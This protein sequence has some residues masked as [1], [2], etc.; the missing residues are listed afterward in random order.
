MEIKEIIKEIEANIGYPKKLQETIK[1]LIDELPVHPDY[2]DFRNK[3]SKTHSTNIQGA[4]ST[5]DPIQKQAI[6]D[7]IKEDVLSF[8]NTKL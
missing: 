6:F 2:T 8:L 7:E 4:I 1:I 3:L 5:T